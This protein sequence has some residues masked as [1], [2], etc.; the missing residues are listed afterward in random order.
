MHGLRDGG[1]ELGPS[2][3]DEALGAA[4]ILQV[5]LSR[6]GSDGVV[7]PVDDEGQFLS[8]RRNAAMIEGRG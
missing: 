4:A 2:G 8:S 7:G 3:S 6:A 1:P 5:L